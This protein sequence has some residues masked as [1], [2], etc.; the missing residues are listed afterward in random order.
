MMTSWRGMAAV[1]LLPASVLMGTSIMRM[2]PSG[3][4]FSAA[5]VDLRDYMWSVGSSGWAG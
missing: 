3:R 5:A 4:L 1:M 2:T